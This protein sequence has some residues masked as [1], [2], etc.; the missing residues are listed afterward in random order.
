MRIALRTE[1]RGLEKG[2][3]PGNDNTPIHEEQQPRLKH[4]GRIFLVF[5]R[6]A[7]TFLKFLPI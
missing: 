1:Y 6:L 5:S 7:E 2:G 3:A 4:T